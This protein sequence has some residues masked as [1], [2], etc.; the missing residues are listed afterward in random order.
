MTRAEAVDVLREAAHSSPSSDVV[1]R[2]QAAV[3][4]FADL[5]ATRG[6]SAAL[7]A[8][9]DLVLDEVLAA[10]R[11]APPVRELSPRR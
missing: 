4:R 1:D 9:L 10:A 3:G 6:D 2:V 7:T 11:A 5:R 8:T